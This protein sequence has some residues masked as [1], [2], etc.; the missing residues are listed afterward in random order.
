MKKLY[1]RLLIVTVLAAF[2]ILAFTLSK[3]GNILPG[4]SKNTGN[5]RKQR[6][7][8]KVDAFVVKP[9]VLIDEIA[10]SGSLRAFE[11]VEL[12]NE[13]AGRV[14]KINLPEGQFVK[15]G[16]LLVKLFDD[17]LQANLHNLHA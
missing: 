7:Q 12:K 11:E 4:F 10:V 5:S 15:K 1:K 13:V 6:P 17:D 14:V 8:L 9:S 16:T 2:V 3:S